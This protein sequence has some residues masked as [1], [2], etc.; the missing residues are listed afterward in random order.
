MASLF[1]KLSDKLKW[2]YLGI[3]DNFPGVSMDFSWKLRWRMRNDRNPL[4]VVIQDKYLVKEYARRKGVRA[5]EEF[6]V[7]DNPETIPFDTLPSNYFIKANHGCKWNIYCK[8]GE[9]Y[10]YSDGEDLIG[11]KNLT[12]YKISR[13]QVIEYC[14][15]WLNTIYSKK[16]WAYG[17]NPPKNYGRGS[18]GAAW[19]WRTYGFR[20]FTFNGVVRA[21]YVDSPTYAVNHQK[22]YVDSNW[23]EFPL[24][25]LQEVTPHI[26]P[27]KPDNFNE[28]IEV[29]EK[30]G[31]DFD[32][33]R[34]DLYNASCGITL[35]EMSVY[36]MGGISLQP[37]PDEDFNKWL[38]DYWILPFESNKKS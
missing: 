4:F 21:V 9:F 11:R 6:Y 12:K 13:D 34:I 38:G 35:G 29:A 28:L 32:F 3:V 14:K 31:R 26:L 16:E 24:K 37:T 33:V 8:N 25:N 10:Y 5:T 22:I 17:Q 18:L 15:V 7:T 30:L 20:C 36:P 19:R 27:Q 2:I 23:N 1:N